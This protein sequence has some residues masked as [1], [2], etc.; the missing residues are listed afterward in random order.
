M[1]APLHALTW[2]TVADP[3]PLQTNALHLWRLPLTSGDDSADL[4]LLS[5]GQR[6]RLGRLRSPVHRR[7]YLR[8]QA[9]CRRILARY[10]AQPPGALEFH[11][12]AAGKPFLAAAIRHPEFNLT[13]S[14]DLALLAVS[15]ALPVGVDCELERE[16]RDPL[17]IA[18]R[19][20][21]PD[22]QRDLARRSGRDR[23]R[24]FHLHWT[25]LE[26]RVKA[27]G[28]GL[29]RHREPDLPALV[30]R[31]AIAGELGGCTAVC[32]VARVDLPPPERWLA[33]QWAG[34]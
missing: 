27:D 32:A 19:M 11:R 30:V 2:Q 26:A 33:L 12:G 6:Q 23:L 10:V 28:R 13:N 25:A 3:P 14:G 15:A 29:A 34:D 17:A 22:A 20:L 8:T 18:R 5:D 9:G 31:H 4:A 24:A 21:D 16:R 1:T 7:R